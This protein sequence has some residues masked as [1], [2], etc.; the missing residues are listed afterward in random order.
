MSTNVWTKF[1]RLSERA[2]LMIA[3][4]L[5]ISGDNS[6]VKDLYDQEYTVIG[7]N[8]PVGNKCF[9]LDGIIQNQAPSLPQSTDVIV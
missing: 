1:K 5:S 7:S 2:D 6:I 8:I 9:I 4:V 3:T